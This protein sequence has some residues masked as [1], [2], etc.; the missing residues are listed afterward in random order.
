AYRGQRGSR[1]VV[2]PDPPWSDPFIDAALPMRI[3]WLPRRHTP[4]Q[5][6]SGSWNL[7]ATDGPSFNVAMSQ[8]VVSASPGNA[9]Q[10][11]GITASFMRQQIASAFV[12]SSK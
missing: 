6:P 11:E 4:S 1:R 3:A 12:P 10:A 5:A 9:F 2:G 8:G 7:V